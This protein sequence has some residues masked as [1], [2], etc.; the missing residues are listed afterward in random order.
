MFGDNKHIHGLRIRTLLLIL[1]MIP[2]LAS[3]SEEIDQSSKDNTNPYDLVVVAP[4]SIPYHYIDAD[5]N[6]PIGT[7]IDRI[8]KLMREAELGRPEFKVYPWKR[9]LYLANKQPRTLIMPLSRT[10]EREEDYFWLRV[11]RETRF[12]VF[13]LADEAITPKLI[14]EQEIVI[15]CENGGIQCLL[16]AQEGVPER[17]IKQNEGVSHDRVLDLALAGRIKYFLAEQD[18]VEIGLKERGL[19]ID[20]LKNVYTLPTPVGDYLA[21]A[22]KNNNPEFITSLFNALSRIFNY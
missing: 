14:S 21:I 16:L 5:T 18:L 11:L 22:K 13:S 10:P 9:A 7:E 8:T 2:I 15:Y 3:A 1:T 17:L 12:S 4:E 6:T 20:M 19:D